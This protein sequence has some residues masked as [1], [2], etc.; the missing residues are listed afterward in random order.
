MTDRPTTSPRRRLSQQDRHAQLLAVARELVRDEG[1]DLLTLGR[2]AERAG[3]T[4]PVV[5]DHFG[6]RAGVLA[7]LYRAFDARQ[8]AVLDAALAETEQTLPA[9]A[10]VVAGAYVDCCLAEGRELADVVSALSGSAVL[11]QLRQDAEDGYL[12]KC[13]AA[14]EPFAGPVDPAGLRA[15]VGAG[16]ALARA[17][18]TGRI[19]GD[20]ARQTLARV[21]QAVVP[22]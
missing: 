16:D 9:V 6:N 22:A 13:S 14:L 18:L 21:I 15:V 12:A 10:A 4:K 19:D 17:A 8:H 7:E 1:T 3:V 5:Y 20:Q 2:L 11:D